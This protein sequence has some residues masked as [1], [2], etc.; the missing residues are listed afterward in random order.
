MLIEY[1]DILLLP[2]RSSYRYSAREPVELADGKQPKKKKAKRVHRAD[3]AESSSDNSSGS[4]QTQLEPEEV[5]QQLRDEKNRVVALSG[6]LEE[7]QQHAM[8]LTEQLSEQLRDCKCDELSGRCDN[9]AAN[10]T[11]WP[12]PASDC[13]TR[14][15][16]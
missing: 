4:T 7:E 6:Q 13:A 16:S 14:S 10:A 3:D 5:K 9:W 15:N 11:S 1:S 2:D 12:A 8:E